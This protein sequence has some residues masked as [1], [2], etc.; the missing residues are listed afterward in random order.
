MIKYVCIG[1]YITSRTDGQRHF[2]SAHELPALYSV[3]PYEC[4]FAENDQSPILQGLRLEDLTILRPRSNGHYDIPG[5]PHI[6]TTM[7]CY[8]ICSKGKKK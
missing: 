2:I 5:A 4:Y 6:C 8:P 7:E 3:Y 1:G